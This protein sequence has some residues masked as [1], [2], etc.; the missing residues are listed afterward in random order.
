[1][2]EWLLRDGMSPEAVLWTVIVQNHGIGSPECLT[3]TLGSCHCHSFWVFPSY[4]F[5]CFLESPWLLKTSSLVSA[6]V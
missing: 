3:W 1:M 4:V 5:S 6:W 2:K